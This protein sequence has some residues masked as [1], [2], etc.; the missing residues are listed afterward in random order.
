MVH[1]TVP[2][3]FDCKFR[4]KELQR[5]ST[6]GEEWVSPIGV[7]GAHEVSYLQGSIHRACEEVRSPMFHFTSDCFTNDTKKDSVMGALGVPDVMHHS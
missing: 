6:L 7:S 5:D 3:T 2:H 1:S 4:V